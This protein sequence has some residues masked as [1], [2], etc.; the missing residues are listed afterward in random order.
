MVNLALTSCFIYTYIHNI[1]IHSIYV[2]II[3]VYINLFLF[4]VTHDGAQSSVLKNHY[5]K[6]FRTIC[7]AEIW[8]SLLAACAYLLVVLS[9][10]MTWF[11]LYIIDYWSN[12]MI[13]ARKR[14][15]FHIKCIN[16]GFYSKKT[17]INIH[18]RLIG[19]FYI[20]LKYFLL[21]TC[22]IRI[23]L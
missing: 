5:W 19:R 14:K 20:I 2:Y 11:L 21:L 18:H 7:S 10:A 4:R 15:Y 6:C 13:G 1:C 8:T 17:T 23:Y 16:F 22:G 3:Y 9:L 12:T